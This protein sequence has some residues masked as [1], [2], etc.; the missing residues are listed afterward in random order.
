MP[1]ALRSKLEQELDRLV[2][3]GIIEPVIF[4][5]NASP[6]VPIL[7]HDGRIRLCAD[8]STTIDKQ[9]LM[10]KYPLPRIDELFAKLRVKRNSIRFT[11]LDLSSPS[12]GVRTIM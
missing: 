3:L 7:K 9:L 6:I 4:L 10:E 11:K 12:K 1:F 8:Y 5:A 2:N